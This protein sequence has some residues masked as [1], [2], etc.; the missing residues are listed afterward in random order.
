MN[1]SLV[2]DFS[3]I[4]EIEDF[5]KKLQD[6]HLLP[7]HFGSNLD[8]LND[9]ITGDI[10]LPFYLSFINMSVEQLVEF[11]ALIELLKEINQDIK[12]FSFAYFLKFPL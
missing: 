4:N 8:A 5:Y 6:A 1:H 10:A 7:E 11:K 2:V 12:A 9:V 3:E